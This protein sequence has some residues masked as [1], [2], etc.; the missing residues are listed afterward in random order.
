MRYIFHHKAAIA[1]INKVEDGFA[2]A[3]ETGD[4]SLVKHYEKELALSLSSHILYTIC[5]TNLSAKASSPTGTLLNAIEKNFK[6]FDKFKADVT[7][8]TTSVEDAG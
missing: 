4:F 7:A 6:T 8:V 2:L 1:A 3:C 5:W